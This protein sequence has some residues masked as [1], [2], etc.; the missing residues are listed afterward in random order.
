MVVKK[1]P[2]QKALTSA[3]FWP[4]LPKTAVAIGKFAS[5]PGKFW[6]GCPSADKEKRFMC[7]V[8]DFVAVHDFGGGRKGSAFKLKEMGEDGRGSLE[9]GV[10][11]GE[12]FVLAY[13]LPFLEYY[14]YANRAELPDAM[15]SKVFPDAEA[16]SAAAA[17]GDNAADD[18]EGG[19]VV[20]K[21]EKQ[22]RPPIFDFFEEVSSTLA[23]AGPQRGKYTI[24]YKCTVLTSSGPCGGAATCYKTGDGKAETTSNAWTHLRDKAPSCPAHAAALVQLNMTNRNVVQLEDGEFVKVMNFAEAFPHHVDYVWCRA[25]G[26]FSAIMG[27]KPLFRKYV[28]GFEPRAVFPHHEVQYNIALCIKELQDEEQLARLAALQREFKY[29]PCI[30]A[31]LDMWTDTN[32]HIA[33]GGINVT[34]VREPIIFTAGSTGTPAM[35]STTTT[36]KAPQ[37]R[38]SSEVLDFAAFPST[39]HTGPAIKDWFGGVIEAKGIRVSS[40][41]GVSPDG[42]ADGQCGLRLVEGLADKVDTCN[43]HGLQ[44]TVLY[45]IGIAGTTSKN[46]EAKSLLKLHNRVSQ[47]SNQSR[48]VSDGIRNGQLSSDVPLSK[49]LSTVDTC[50]TRWGNQ[51]RQISRNNTLKPVIDPVVETYK[52]ENRGKKDAIVEDDDSNPTSRVGKAV[53]ASAIGLSSEQWDTSLEVE[54]FL[55]HPFQIKESIEHK[56]YVTGA[57]SLF[58]LHDLKKGCT[59]DKGLTVK[60][61]PSTPKVEDRVRP[62]ETRKAEDLHTC[63]G[64]ARSVM[65]SELDDRFFDNAER[66]SNTRLVQCWMSKQRPADKWMPEA[67]R[68]LAKGLYLAMLRE[69][70]KIS[71]IGVRSSPPRKVAKTIGAGSSSLVRNVS[72]DESEDEPAVQATEYDTVTDEASRWAALD[73]KTIREFRDGAGIVNEFA[74]VYHLRQSFPLHFI[75]F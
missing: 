65:V 3:G 6:E 2:S 38:A 57:T 73:P 47:L 75:V 60:A 44:R 25:R 29:G 11:S 46:L 8:V 16:G 69:A 12:E 40:L 31:Q 53:P 49:L 17:S 50:T 42:A 37:L 28:R 30:G 74:L 5:M 45:S 51:F 13:P 15:R 1:K 61:H 23:T 14:Y 36:K 59:E 27:S 7:V 58:L 66:P 48:A 32:T 54:A 18:A 20:V 22:E 34:T 41:S 24:K 33:Y 67:W 63:I 62:T 68:V 35:A 52:R 21:Q 43:L 56:G 26:I 10:A 64:T 19:G 4:L 39:E 9:P 55:D 72:D 71:G 70:A